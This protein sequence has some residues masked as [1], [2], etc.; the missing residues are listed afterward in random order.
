MAAGG[1]LHRLAARRGA[2]VEDRFGIPGNQPCRQRG[3]K[4][5]DPPASAREAGQLGD[6]AAG[7]SDVAR[8]ER[9]AVVLSRKNIRIR[10]VGEG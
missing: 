2:E 7:E 6:G 5:L 10:N 8:R 9:N 3:G 4:V 1:K